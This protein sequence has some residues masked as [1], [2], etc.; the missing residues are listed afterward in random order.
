M[1]KYDSNIIYFKERGWIKDTTHDKYNNWSERFDAYTDLLKNN[2]KNIFEIHIPPSK[3]DFDFINKHIKDVSNIIL[4]YKDQYRETPFMHEISGAHL[5]YGLYFNEEIPSEL[6][7][8]MS[9]LLKNPEQ[10]TEERN[11]LARKIFAFQKSLP[12]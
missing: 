12:S 2:C 5:R 3:S 9:N 10:T 4:K 11:N 1:D 8:L 6:N 7:Q